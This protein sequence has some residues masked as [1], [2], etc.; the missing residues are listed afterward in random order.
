MV[1]TATRK[2][3]GKER[4]TLGVQA[5]SVSLIQVGRSAQASEVGPVGNGYESHVIPFKTGTQLYSHYSF[6][7][8][9]TATLSMNEK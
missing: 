1:V 6:P 9:H 4:I 3:R 2:C 5:T 8:A 7:K